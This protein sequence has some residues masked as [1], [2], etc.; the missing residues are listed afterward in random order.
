MNLTP[1]Q[2]SA[3]RQRPGYREQQGQSIPDKAIPTKPPR[4]KLGTGPTAVRKAKLAESM[5]RRG[6]WCKRLYVESLR[7]KGV[8]WKHPG[9][10]NRLEGDYNDRLVILRSCGNVRGFEYEPFSFPIATGATY[11]PDFIVL[12]ADGRIE[13]IE[14]KGF[15]RESAAL[16]IKIFRDKYPWLPLRV[17]RRVK[18]EWVSEVADSTEEIHV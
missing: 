8:T 4:A 1:A 16:R 5:N 14:V 13:A 17:V 6:D 7:N 3:L 18:G 2:R 12:Y 15:M 11:C 9:P 10:M